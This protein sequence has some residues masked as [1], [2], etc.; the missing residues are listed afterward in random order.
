[1]PLASSA[2]CQQPST[3]A[4]YIRNGVTSFNN[5]RGAPFKVALTDPVN[6][7]LRTTAFV[8]N[9]KP[10]SGVFF[11]DAVTTFKTPFGIPARCANST[12]ANADN[13]VSG[14]GFMTTVH[15][16]AKAAPA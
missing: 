6:E 13:G 9:S 2:A 4:W 12:S 3:V 5:Q 14:A 15:P 7:I 8:L 10:T 16:A 1:M 11:F